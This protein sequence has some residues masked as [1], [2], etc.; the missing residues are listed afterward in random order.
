M[1]K[2]AQTELLYQLN[3]NRKQ[4]HALEK[5]HEFLQR[6]E[7]RKVREFHR[8]KDKMQRF[9]HE[10]QNTTGSL[11]T[12]TIAGKMLDDRD[13]DYQRK[14]TSFRKLAERRCETPHDNHDERKTGRTSRKD[15]KDDEFSTN[16]DPNEYF[17]SLRRDKSQNYVAS[18]I[19]AKAKTFGELQ[20]KRGRISS[21]YSTLAD[22]LNSKVRVY[23][24]L[25][26]KQSNGLIF[27]QF[28]SLEGQLNFGSLSKQRRYSLPADSR[29]QQ[30]MTT[31]TAR[32]SC[33]TL[34]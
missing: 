3:K 4:A 31:T 14:L 2:F 26:V 6:Q 22:T 5:Y 17:V 33:P 21:H 23:K 25:A 28:Q 15:R 13:D 29:A 20:S 1:S 11:E 18:Q 30:R 12:A 10:V 8:E 34:N 32:G 24:P 9:L 16:S 7:E 27:P 19:Q